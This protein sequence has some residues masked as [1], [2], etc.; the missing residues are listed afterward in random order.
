MKLSE[1]KC[2]GSDGTLVVLVTVFLIMAGKVQPESC[3][4]ATTVLKQCHKSFK[5]AMNINREPTKSSERLT[6]VKNYGMNYF[7]NDII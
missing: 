4:S 7:A 6:K 2:H 5:G 1:G 3:K